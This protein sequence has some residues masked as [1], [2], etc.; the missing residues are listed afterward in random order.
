MILYQDAWQ[1]L[2]QMLL[3]R[4]PTPL[5]W[6]ACARGGSPPPCCSCKQLNISRQ[7][8]ELSRKAMSI[9]KFGF[10]PP[11]NVLPNLVKISCW[12]DLRG[13]FPS[14]NESIFKQSKFCRYSIDD[15]AF[16]VKMRGCFSIC[17]TFSFLRISCGPLRYLAAI[18]SSFIPFIHF[19]MTEE[20]NL[21]HWQIRQPFSFLL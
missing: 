16:S 7:S 5:A 21:E 18:K 1:R 3:K 6:L 17:Q 19:Q 12:G 4:D 14:Y 20:C 11:E 9:W 8:D 15:T 2:F 13:W 10:F